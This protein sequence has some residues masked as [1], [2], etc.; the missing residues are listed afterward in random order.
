M[1]KSKDPIKTVHIVLTESLYSR[2]RAYEEKSKWNLSLIIREAL[3]K[4]LGEEGE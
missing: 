2:L 3:L 4:F 1:R